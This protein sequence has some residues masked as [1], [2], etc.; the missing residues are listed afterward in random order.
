[1]HRLGAVFFFPCK[2]HQAKVFAARKKRDIRRKINT[3]ECSLELDKS[4]RD[5]GGGVERED[6]AKNERISKPL[7]Q[8]SVYYMRRPRLLVM[9]SYDLARVFS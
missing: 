1:M 5:G 2:I 6:A 8:M 4:R 9:A 3:K 7:V